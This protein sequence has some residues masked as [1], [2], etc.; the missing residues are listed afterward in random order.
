[1]VLTPGVTDPFTLNYQMA[2]KSF[3]ETRSLRSRARAGGRFLSPA[4]V[5]LLLICLL[6][7]GLTPLPSYAARQ[8]RKAT[9]EK[10]SADGFAVLEIELD[11][12]PESD[13]HRSNWK[14]ITYTL[15]FDG[16]IISGQSAQIKG[17]GNYTWEQPKRPCA[18]RCDEKADWFGFGKARDWVLLA[19]ITD[20][21]QMR[22]L[23]AFTLAARFNFDFTPQCRPAHVFIDGKYNGL[24]LI[25]EKIEIDKQRLALDEKGGDM[26][27]ELDNNY[28]GGE[29]DNFRSVL[30][31]TYVP[32]DP[33]RDEMN[34]M[35]DKTVSFNQALKNAKNKINDFE[36]AI[37]TFSGY[38]NFSQYMDMDSLVDWYI[39]NEIM[40]NDDTLFNSSIYLYNDYDGMLHMGPVWDYDLA[41]GGIDRNDGKNVDPEGFMF[42]EDYWG[43]PNWFTYIV[44]STTFNQKVKDRW[45]ELYYSGVFEYIFSFFEVQREYLREAYDYNESVWEN[46]GVFVPSNSYDEAVDYLKDFVVRRVAWLNSQWNGSEVTP[47]PV[48][49]TP[50]PTAT[51]PRTKPPRTGEATPAPSEEAPA[52]TAAPRDDDGDSIFSGKY[53]WAGYVLLFV[54]VFAASTLLLFCVYLIARGKG[55]GATEGD[56]ETDG[57]E[58]K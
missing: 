52:E 3:N 37:S 50:E 54:G 45:T 27:I 14:H 43:R 48:E 10:L 2:E 15:R 20:Q 35:T 38:A 58:G 12:Y 57:G 24:Y 13:I 1:M 25:T 9:P 23:I 34:A 56:D 6:T 31:N 30:G 53:A 49:I 4:C 21:S 28:G 8:N 5:L 32:K 41:M 40:K 22:N 18:I 19:N 16:Q 7:A 33:S 36:T 11:G 51:P 17:R 26:I 39:F 46:G 55:G 47:E 42:E 29:A 44:R